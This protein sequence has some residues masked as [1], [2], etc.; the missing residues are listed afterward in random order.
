MISQT[1]E[2]RYIPADKLPDNQSGE[3]MLWLPNYEER[4]GGLDFGGG[5][6][7]RAIRVTPES[8][9]RTTAVLCCVR[10]LAESIAGLKLNIIKT[11]KQGVKEV[12]KN[13]P[14]Q[15][16]LTVKPNNWQ[17]SFEWVEQMML[18]LG[19]YGNAYNEI[20]RDSSGVP[21][22]L[23]PLHPSRMEVEEVAPGVLRYTYTESSG[24][25]STYP[26]DQ[27]Q[28]VRWMSN[29]GINGIVPTEISKEAIHLA[30]CCERFGSKFFMN[31]ARPGVILETDNAITPE[32][33][34][35]LRE[36]WE[37]LHRGVDSSW[38]TAV[39]TNGLKAH[40]MGSNAQESQ[41]LEVRRFQ[42][43][44]ICRIYRVP[45]HLVMDLQRATFNNIEQQSIDFLQFTLTPWLR[46]IEE[47]IHRDVIGFDSPEEAE[48]DT[49]SLLRGDAA[50]RANYYNSLFNLGCLSVNEIRAA[51]SM[52]P[53][54]GGDQRFVQLNMQP[55]E[56]YEEPQ[57]ETVAV[58]EG[59]EVTVDA[60]EIENDTQAAVVED[61][62]K[63]SD[64]AFTGIQ[65][66]QLVDISKQV[67]AG[68]LPRK[69]AIEIVLV[70]FPT[71]DR[72]E[73]EEIIPEQGSPQVESETENVEEETQTVV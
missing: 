7:Q 19:L 26:A 23:N 54:D 52:N 57:T 3:P 14:I 49:R 72:A 21:T 1:K 36:N 61:G 51:E 2:A 24:G 30:Q 40:E 59:D 22:S 58:A 53:V 12:Q 8:S 46:R 5:G 33:A 55:L 11:G 4:S 65:I 29:D 9:L 41:Y 50:S 43:E 63:I 66:Q 38:K 20:V 32:A 31:G 64:T 47:S 45:P 62:G 44:E 16:L 35:Q 17:T 71:I 18:H 69:S 42:V 37:R 39:L 10:T 73:A 28:H 34:L 25:R 68:E 15:K 70:S 13:N 6:G 56:Q 27:I 48:F 67:A 60:S